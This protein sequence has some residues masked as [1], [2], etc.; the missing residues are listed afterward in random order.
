MNLIPV[1]VLD[2][3]GS[4]STGGLIRAF[5]WIIQQITSKNLKRVVVNLSLDAAFQQNVDVALSN[6]RKAGA[7]IVH[8]SGNYAVNACGRMGGSKLVFFF[9]FYFFFF[10]LKSE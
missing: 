4:G 5:D 9:F 2:S 10:F 6:L 8:A 1:R 3:N 7:V